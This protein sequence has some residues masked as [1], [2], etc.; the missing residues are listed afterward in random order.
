MI[1]V[2][3]FYWN[4]YNRS[5][6]MIVLSDANE[7]KEF[8]KLLNDLNQYMKKVHNSREHYNYINGVIIA[9]GHEQLT[10]YITAYPVYSKKNAFLEDIINNC[11]FSIRGSDYYAFFKEYK[12]NIT[13]VRI[14]NNYIEFNT[15]VPLVEQ[16]YEFIDDSNRFKIENYKL[17]G[18]FQLN[19]DQTEVIKEYK[20]SPFS[21]YFYPNTGNCTIDEKLEDD[22]S[23]IRI[24]YNKKFLVGFK[25]TKTSKQDIY[26][27]LYDYNS[28]EN[29]YIIEIIVPSNNIEVKQYILITDI[30]E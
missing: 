28:D 17:L 23:Y 3:K 15:D 29:L 4:H 2:D 26:F 7:V 21:I 20:N 8:C 10:P 18:E 19:S 1:P 24:I 16:K 12:N 13:E 11:R 14:D 9:N 5:D 27:K 25:G 6:N 30:A 22:D